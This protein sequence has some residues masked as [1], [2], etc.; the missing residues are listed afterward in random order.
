MNIDFVR[1]T[2]GRAFAMHMFMEQAHPMNDGLRAPGLQSKAFGLRTLRG[3]DTKIGFE[4]YLN[5]PE[6]RTAGP[7]HSV[8]QMME[9]KM[10]LY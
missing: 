5:I 3:T 7:K 10:G 4:D 1:R 6:L 9:V 2:Y 8:H